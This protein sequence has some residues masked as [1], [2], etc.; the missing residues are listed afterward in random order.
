MADVLLRG[1]S[2]TARVASQTAKDIVA[3]RD[4]HRAATNKNAKA[5]VLLDALYRQPTVSVNKVSEVLSCTFPTAAKL[6][7]DFEE[8]GWLREVTGYGRNRVW[9]YQPY[10]D[11]FHRDAIE[12]MVVPRLI[13]PCLQCTARTEHTI[14]PSVPTPIPIDTAQYAAPSAVEVAASQA[15]RVRVTDSGC[16]IVDR[17]PLSGTTTRRAPATRAAI[18]S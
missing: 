9:R 11:L 17:W 5:L 2:V 7:R 4:S 14:A 18:A 6:I 12:A 13:R 15:E 8:R 1:V 3:L 16:S 10:V